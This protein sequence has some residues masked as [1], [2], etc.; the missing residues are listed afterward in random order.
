[1]YRIRSL[2]DDDFDALKTLIDQTGVGLT[3]LPK[4][5][6]RIR[7]LV[8]NGAQSFKTDVNDAFYLFVLEHPE[9]L[10]L[11]GTS[12]I[13]A[14]SPHKDQLWVEELGLSPLF[15][16][17]PEHVSILTCKKNKDNSSEICA[18]YLLHKA[19]QEGLGKLLSYSRFH[20]IAAHPS[21][22][23]KSLFADLRGFID[24]N[25]ESPF[26]NAVGRHFLD[27]DF[28]HLMKLRDVDEDVAFE[29]M[30]KL[31]IY[32]ELLPK[33][34]QLALGEAHPH[35]KAALEMLIEQGFVKSKE[36]DLYDG[37]PRVRAS[38]TEIKTIKE[39]KRIQIQSIVGK[40]EDKPV[41]LSNEREDFY[42]CHGKIDVDK[43][44][45]DLE[46][47]SALEV[48]PGEFIRYSP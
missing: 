10:E 37:G 47:A 15:P 20:Y 3:S 36:F 33:S 7:E 29:L 34:A 22:F 43:G 38:I 1:M 11:L 44:I 17:V 39:S 25:D 19:R 31:P 42:A 41:L 6:V 24:I 32:L 30:P 2:R 4:N 45:I 16:E 40:L 13:Y 8:K 48:K 14:K 18:L 28:K 46:T 12:G 26:W 9:T 23:S 35:S 21:K 5:D 27:V